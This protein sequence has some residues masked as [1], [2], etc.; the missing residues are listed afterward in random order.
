[1]KGQLQKRTGASALACHTCRWFEDEDPDI[2]YCQLQREE[3][4]GLCDEYLQSGSWTDARTEW[5]VT[6]DL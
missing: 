3:F 5:K 6:D 1:M 2:F 4:P